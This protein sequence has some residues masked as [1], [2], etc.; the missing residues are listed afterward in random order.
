M[1]IGFDSIEGK[2]KL[3]SKKIRILIYRIAGIKLN[4]GNP[5]IL[6]ILVQTSFSASMKFST[7]CGD[8]ARATAFIRALSFSVSVISLILV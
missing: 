8:A 6:K 7:S 1:R 5:E 4:L 2:A 3:S